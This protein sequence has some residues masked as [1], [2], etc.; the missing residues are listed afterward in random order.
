LGRLF[1]STGQR[2]SSKIRQ[3]KKPKLSRLNKNIFNFRSVNVGI[4]PWIS[5][6]HRI[7]K[8]IRWCEM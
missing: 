5:R 8:L 4:L 2:S 1:R 6:G 7:L 3:Q